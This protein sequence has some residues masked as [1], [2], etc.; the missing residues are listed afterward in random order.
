MNARIFSRILAAVLTAILVGYLNITVNS[1]VPN[2]L[3]ETYG[4]GKIPFT[5]IILDPKQSPWG[6]AIGD[7]DGDGFVDALAGFAHGGVY[8]YAYPS[9]ARHFIGNNGG[10]DLQVADI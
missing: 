6:K 9:W 3:A 10:D 4:D 7:I 5:H 1:I 2:T 8:W